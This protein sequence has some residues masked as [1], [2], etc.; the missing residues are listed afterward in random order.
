MT[1]LVLSYFFL[2]S[3]LIAHAQ[4]DHIER[5]KTNLEESTSIEDTLLSVITLKAVNKKYVE[6]NVDAL[7]KI[8]LEKHPR[9]IEVELAI[10]KG[11]NQV[12]QLLNELLANESSTKLR[13]YVSSLSHLFSIKSGESVSSNDDWWTYQSNPSEKAIFTFFNG[14]KLRNTKHNVDSIAHYF[15][16]VYEI[17]PQDKFPLLQLYCLNAEL[18]FRLSQKDSSDIDIMH[19]GIT[20]SETVPEYYYRARF[21]NLLQEYLKNQ[22]KTAE[23]IQ[24][25]QKFIE[26][27]EKDGN[28]HNTVLAYVNQ[29]AYHQEQGRFEKAYEMIARARKIALEN[30][31]TMSLSTTFSSEANA[32]MNEKKY[33]EAVPLLKKAIDLVPNTYINKPL[34]ILNLMDTYYTVGKL[35]SAYYYFQYLN[36]IDPKDSYGYHAYG[37]TFVAQYLVEKGKTDLAQEYINDA[38]ADAKAYNDLSSESVVHLAQSKL[39][40]SKGQY[41]KALEV[42]KKHMDLEQDFRNEDKAA[43]I[44]RAQMNF[45]FSKEKELITLQNESKNLKVTSQRNKALFAGALALSLAIFGLVLY[46]FTKR[47]NK[48]ISEQ[49]KRLDKLNDVKDQIFQIIGHDLRKPSLAFRGIGKNINYLLEKGDTERLK[50]MGNEIEKDA[51][52]FYNITDNLLNWAAQQKGLITLNPQNVNLHSVVQE[53]MDSFAHLVE[54]KNILLTN[55]VDERQSLFADKE[56]LM[57]IVRNLLDNAIKFSSRGGKIEVKSSVTGNKLRLDV[58]DNGLGIESNRLNEILSKDFVTSTQGTA[59]EKGSGL[60]L[61]I[62]KNMIE[63]LNGELK[64]QSEISKGSTFSVLI[65]V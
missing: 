23:A 65:P 54:T 49:N 16:Q 30:R 13:S 47:K 6:D 56:S 41:E 38:Y 59:S 8:L 29:A 28:A 9:W 64:V 42:F 12:E 37:K 35:D 5:F 50:K 46:L 40:E 31:D 24:A 25:G 34:Y 32:K 15:H 57:V 17:L 48:L 33:D 11:D 21:Y 19:Q 58:I 2:F 44:T 51:V 55:A 7:N 10:I 39:Y 14:L 27:S 20:L 62:V 43:E 45:E 63:K 26:C 60:G 52:Q 36:R 18:Q 4:T 53:S 22:G 61:N 3:F 1:K